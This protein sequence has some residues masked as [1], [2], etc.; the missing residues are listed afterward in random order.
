MQTLRRGDRLLVTAVNRSAGPVEVELT[1]T[2]AGDQPLPVRAVVPAHRSLT[3]LQVPVS[4]GAPR[5]E[6]RAVPGEPYRVA[7]DVVYSLPVEESRVELGQGFHGGFSHD[8]P[9]NRYAVDLIVPEGTPVFAA[10]AGV[11]V[12]TRAGHSEGGVDPSLRSRA[13]FVR[14]LHDDGSMALY[15][16][17]RENGVTVRPGQ[18]VT[19]GQVLG[20]TGNTGF[21]SGPHLHFAVQVNVGMRLES[22][23]FRM[24]GPQGLLR[25]DRR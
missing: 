1:G 21:S 16:H 25:L 2:A 20:Y 3:L 17:L 19:L 11:V 10:R 9:G 4:A 22:V 6:L 12:Q 8:D 7:R 14:V 23:P 5:L 15:A 18:Q 24:I 13:N